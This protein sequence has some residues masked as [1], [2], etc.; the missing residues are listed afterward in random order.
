MVLPDS[1]RWLIARGRIEEGTRILAQ[2]EDKELDDPEVLEKKKEIE[3]SL[4]QESAGGLHR[5]L[6]SA[7]DSL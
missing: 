4:M 3:V 2:L 7:C 1:P 6:L 5:T